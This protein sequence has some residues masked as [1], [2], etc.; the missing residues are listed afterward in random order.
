MSDVFEIQ[1]EGRLT[2][3]VGAGE[4]ILDVLEVTEKCSRAVREANGDELVYMDRLRDVML[5]LGF[6][7]MSH[8]ANHKIAKRFWDRA[9]ELK[10]KEGPTQPLGNEQES[11]TTTT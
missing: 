9:E 11:A 4:H 2:I 5:G 10:K 8:D 1:D 3:R 6:E 7:A